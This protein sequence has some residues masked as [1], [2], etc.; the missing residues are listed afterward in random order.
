MPFLPWGSRTA[1]LLIVKIAVSPESSTPMFWILLVVLSLTASFEPRTSSKIVSKSL[2]R[3]CG[4]GRT[5][6]ILIKVQYSSRDTS[7]CLWNSSFVRANDGLCVRVLWCTWVIFSACWTRRRFSMSSRTTYLM[8]PWQPSTSKG[9]T[10][11]PRTLKVMC[12]GR[13]L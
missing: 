10:P 7:R 2:L 8:P 13:A 12:L 1:V 3:T 6:G 5:H 9:D 11:T 4:F